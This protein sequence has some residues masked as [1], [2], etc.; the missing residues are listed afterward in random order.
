[1]LK[2]YGRAYFT[3]ALYK[4]KIIKAESSYPRL[5]RVQIKC[6]PN[7]RNVDLEE[8]K[9]CSG[10]Y[11]KIGTMGQCTSYCLGKIIEENSGE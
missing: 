6:W 8:T 3:K 4:R 10:G 11:C 1:M 9:K 2:Y 5:L 7:I